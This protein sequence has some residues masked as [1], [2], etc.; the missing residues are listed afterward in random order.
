MLVNAKTTKE[1]ETIEKNYF[2]C[3]GCD[4]KHDY[5]HVLRHI[6]D[7]GLCRL[8]FG[9]WKCFSCNTAV[10][11]AV[12]KNGDVSLNTTSLISDQVK[13][14][15]LL[16][17]R[18]ELLNKDSTMFIIIESIS[19]N[20]DINKNM[21]YYFNNYIC[22]VNYLRVPIIFNGDMDPHGIFK[23]VKTIIYPTNE[24]LYN[25]IKEFGDDPDPS[26]L[27][28]SNLKIG[29]IEKL[30]DIKLNKE[31]LVNL[32]FYGLEEHSF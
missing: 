4:G 30:F 26:R 9:P 16:S 10:T 31:T 3:P 20:I 1:V 7:K 17:L 18:E 24:I 12:M 6:K 8:N 25:I 21:K 29:Y 22:P 15:S 32:D 13:T 19:D 11:G 27:D 14:L 28:I 5:S 2:K 23:H